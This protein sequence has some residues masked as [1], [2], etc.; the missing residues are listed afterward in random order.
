MLDV[1]LFRAIGEPTRARLL[2]CLIKCGR[3]CSVSEV[4]ECCEVDFSVVARHLTQLAR[5]EV[6]ESKKDGRRV[7]YHA[8]RDELSAKL[9]ALADAVDEWAGPGADADCCDEAGCERCS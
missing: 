4:A 1:D 6:L 3:P 2:G 7:L 5:A 9:R 8:K